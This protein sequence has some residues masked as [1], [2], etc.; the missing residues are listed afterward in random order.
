MS[1]RMNRIIGIRGLLIASFLHLV[2][3][4]A[5]AT[6][7]S[8]AKVNL[9]GEQIVESPGGRLKVRVL[10]VSLPKKLKQFAKIYPAPGPR[11]VLKGRLRITVVGKTEEFGPGQL[12]WESGIQALSENISDTEAEILVTETTPES[13]PSK[14][15]PERADKTKT[16]KTKKQ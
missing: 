4:D 10:K 6:E 2:S 7:T 9:L 12:F 11:Y 15:K 8:L 16:G 3:L 1:F 14:A 13:S 5:L